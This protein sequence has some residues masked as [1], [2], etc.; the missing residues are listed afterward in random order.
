MADKAKQHLT[1]HVWLEGL[2]DHLDGAAQVV[3]AAAVLLQPE[4]HPHALQHLN[5][6]MD[7][8]RVVEVEQILVSE[9]R[10]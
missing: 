8:K 2:G 3:G 10:E 9:T 1:E 5:V 6:V 7:L 4:R